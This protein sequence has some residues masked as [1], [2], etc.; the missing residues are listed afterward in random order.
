MPESKSGQDNYKGKLHNALSRLLLAYTAT[1]PDANLV[2]GHPVAFGNGFEA[3]PRHAYFISRLHPSTPV[4]QIRDAEVVG[5]GCM[6]WRQIGAFYEY[7]VGQTSDGNR[8]KVILLSTAAGAIQTAERGIQLI[9]DP[10]EY[11]GLINPE[12]EV[13]ATAHTGEHGNP[14]SGGCGGLGYFFRDYND[15]PRR[16]TEGGIDKSVL[17]KII[18]E[19]PYKDDPE[20]AVTAYLMTGVNQYIPTD[21]RRKAHGI[22][23]EPYENGDGIKHMTPTPLS[24]GI[25]HGAPI[26]QGM[27]AK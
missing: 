16:A 20:L 7:L 12:I 11:I 17:E 27:I 26:F 19:S 6:D 25:F 13:I 14:R 10:L 1:L 22:V 9:E 5:I 4:E 23:L 15:D 2:H 8:S 24:P 21:L 18:K 3:P